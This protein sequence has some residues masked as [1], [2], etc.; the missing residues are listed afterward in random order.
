MNKK[1][2]DKCG[3]EIHCGIRTDSN[4]VFP[5]YFQLDICGFSGEGRLMNNASKKAHLCESCYSKLETFLDS[6]IDSSYIADEVATNNTLYSITTR[7]QEIKKQFFHNRNNESAWND[8][9]YA[10]KYAAS[11]AIEDIC[12]LLDSLIKRG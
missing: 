10:F 6:K 1:I 11:R 8:P 5:N 4:D 7:A 3:C 12:D 9:N 2:C